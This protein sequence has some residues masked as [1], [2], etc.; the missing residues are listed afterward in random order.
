MKTGLYSSVE[1]NKLTV[2]AFIALGPSAGKLFNL[3][4]GKVVIKD[5]GQALLTDGDKNASGFIQPMRETLLN[6][7][8]QCCCDWL[9][10]TCL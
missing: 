1:A 3:C 5:K 6:S 8:F 4:L 2:A 7:M 9:T 10:W